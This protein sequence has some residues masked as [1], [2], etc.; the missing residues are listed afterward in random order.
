MPQLLARFAC[1]TLALAFVSPA[2]ATRPLWELGAGLTVLSLPDYRGS[3]VR[4]VHVLPIPY[5]A[6]RGEFIR[7]DEDGLRGLLYDSERLELNVSVNGTLPSL[8]EDNPARVG[9]EELSP[10]VEIGPTAD[11]HLWWSVDRRTRLDLRLPLRTAIT[12]ESD[13]Q[14]IGWLFAPNL[15]LEMK[16]VAGHAG[17]DAS[18]QAGPYFNDREYNAYFYGVRPHEATATRPAYDASGGYSGAQLM[19]TLSKRFP[20]FWVG[21]FVR[22][23]SL[24]GAV[25]TDSPLVETRHA[26][27]AGVGAS[28]IF[29]RSSRRVGEDE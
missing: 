4:N 3:D 26:V 19:L 22:Y 23:D 13:P 15:I 9:M 5:L 8:T 18:V 14:Q 10:T 2:Q 1:A 24:D 27:S 6:Y 29:A 17:W 12:V 25:Y 11:F 28:W 21:A 7:A 20:R 16:D